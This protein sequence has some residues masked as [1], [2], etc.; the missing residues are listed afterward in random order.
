MDTKFDV[1]E[2]EIPDRQNKRSEEAWQ[3]LRDHV[4]SALERYSNVHRGSGHFSM[5]TS[6]LFEQAR[7]V[8]LNYLNL[9]AKKYVVLFLTPRRAAVFRKLLTPGSYIGLASRDIGLPLGIEALAIQRKALPK[10]VAFQS[11]GGT[12]RLVAPRWVIRY[13]IPRLFEA[14]TPAII[15]IIT[16]SGALQMIREYGNNV[17]LV[18]SG[19][20]VNSHEI[21]FHDAMEE[22][23]G[24]ELFDKLRM[25][26]IGQNVEVRVPEGMRPF[27]NLDNAASTPAFS[28]VWQ[29]ACVTW[30]Q[31]AHIQ[32]EMIGKVCSLCAEF[33]GASPENY[34][35]IFTSNTTEAINLVAESLHLERHPEV[36]TVVVNTLLEH[37]SNE[38]PWREITGVSL[39]R[40]GADSEGFPDIEELERLLV[41]Y[42]QECRQGNKRIR[43]V[44]VTG[45]SNVLGTYTNL[46][47]IS[48]TVHRYGACLMVD[49]AQLTAHRKVEMEKWGIDFLAFSGHKM[50]APFGTGVLA[51]RKGLLNFQPDQMAEIRK[52]G[53]ENVT[54]IAALGKSLLLLQRIG[55]DV[56][57]KEEQALTRRAL[58]GMSK[59]RGLRLY[60]IKDTD[61][62]QFTHKGGVIPFDFR[63]VMS[64][65]IAKELNTLGGIGVRAG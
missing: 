2:I 52:S 36:E 58:E 18:P 9:D 15:N 31:P 27:I 35:I 32:R 16:L 50:Y 37:N 51:V 34:D 21:L 60:G 17:F 63:G 41:S 57:R 49:A 48:N 62:P 46:L 59:I 33:L 61:S 14:G 25:S 30:Q 4:F 5:V 40:L 53:E 64:D 6:Q 29:A 8:V 12:A 47:A 7:N 28:P 38:L 24:E 10:R 65:K 54:G 1:P 39:I 26:C 22:S 45:A 43:L 56:I 19:T 44:A 13:G 55:F 20:E 23:T 11:G 3:R 42:N